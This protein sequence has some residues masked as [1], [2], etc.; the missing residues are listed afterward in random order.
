MERRTKLIADIGSN[1]KGIEQAE[2]AVQH[3]AQCGFDVVKFQSFKKQDLYGIQDSSE[4]QFLDI[5]YLET[6]AGRFGIEFMC[7]G[8]C[9]ETCNHLDL[10]VKRHKV[11]SAEAVHLD[12]LRAVR[13]TEKPVIVST[14]GLTQIEVDMIMNELAGCAVTLLECVSNY[15]ADLAHYNLS[16]LA[17]WKKK[18][19]CNVGVSDHCRGKAALAGI[20]LGA[21]V[22]EVHL[23]PFDT[24]G[25]DGKQHGF[26]LG[27]D[28][29]KEFVV[30]ARALEQ[31]IQPHAKDTAHQHEAVGKY[32]RRLKAIAEI[33]PGEKLV[34]GVNYGVYRSIETDLHA[35]HAMTAEMYN[36]KTAKRMLKPQDGIYVTDVQ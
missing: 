16:V 30:T 24:D 3:A 12:I 34:Y 36:G 21:D 27:L 28:E 10:Y 8:F 25:P 13:A 9:P 19:R 15:P 7:T 22:V 17:K 23:D 35:A 31:A 1:W 33:K 32:K 2:L 5:D 26:S 11:A 29:A 20:A 14:G 4:S 6:I 18:Y